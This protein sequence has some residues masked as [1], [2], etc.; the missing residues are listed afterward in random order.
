MSWIQTWGGRPFDPFTAEEDDV[1][2]GDIAHALSL[3]CRFGGHCQDFYSVAQHCVLMA[4]A[5]PPQHAL[6]AL[7]H[8][9]A[10][11]YL[12]DV[13]RPIKLALP[14]LM[15]AEAKLHRVIMAR[16]DLPWDLHEAVKE[17][18]LRM[19]ATE[20][21]DLMTQCT[22]PWRCLDGVEPYSWQV[23]PW[24][25]GPAERMFLERFHELGGRA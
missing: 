1:R 23:V 25:S 2:I 15:E 9:A 12:G 18:D 10:E 5:V 11:V 16:F 8:D 6:Q 14:E 22:E 19:L 24:A 4:N 20:R 3:I 7:L 21:R 13:C 17:A